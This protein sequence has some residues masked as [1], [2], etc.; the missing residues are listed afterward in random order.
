MLRSKFA[1]VAGVCLASVAGIS[2]L[3]AQ[4]FPPPQIKIIVPFPAGGPT[5]VFGRYVAQALG[6]KLKVTVIVD[7]RPGANGVI[8]SEQ[9]ARSAP[10]GATLLFNATH[11]VITPALMKK[12]P[13]DTEAAFTPIALVATVPN[14][15]VI[16]P[17]LPVQS[18]KE[19]IALAKKEPGKLQFGSFGGAN[20]LAGEL[21]KAMAGVDIAH[22][23]YKGAAPA[24]NDVIAG[25]IP[26]MFDTLTT[27]MPQVQGGNVRV[28]A[29]TSAKRSPA[30]P[31]VPTIEEAGGLKGYEATAWFGLF[32]PAGA[33]T[34]PE[35]KLVEAMKEIIASSEMRAKF[36][37]FGA[38]P[39]TLVGKEFGTFVSAELKK[40]A[41]VARL[42]KIEPQ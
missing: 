7:N 26:M 4:S 12:M 9:V 16:T 5:D 39:G 2:V 3:N 13:Y 8:G 27:I 34:L 23:P 25:H 38:E 10:D 40:W 20:H 37:T 1:L 42:A 6:E 22:I 24:M 30:L 36:A 35:A 17:K 41:D 14:A 32:M 28:L 15:I 29:V 31:D 33:N 11:Q 21:F 19:L 18:L